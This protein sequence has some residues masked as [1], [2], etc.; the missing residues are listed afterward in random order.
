MECGAV[1]R[2]VDDGMV[3]DFLRKE[4]EQR[5]QRIADARL[6]EEKLGGSYAHS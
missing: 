1:W 5:A 3:D 6:L 4:A 2:R